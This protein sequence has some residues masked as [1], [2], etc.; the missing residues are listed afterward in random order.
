MF[1][2]FEASNN[3]CAYG[4]SR[5]RVVEFL[6]WWRTDIFSP[7]G[8]ARGADDDTNCDAFAGACRFYDKLDIVFTL[9]LLHFGCI[10]T[11]EAKVDWRFVM[12]SRLG[13]SR[14]K[15]NW[16]VFVRCFVVILC[17]CSLICILDFRYACE[18]A[19]CC[20]E[21]AVA[22]RPTKNVCFQH[23]CDGRSSLS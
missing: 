21:Y 1:F 7:S 14:V 8:F 6:A 10:C 15:W 18:N 12:Q 20:S 23:S 19:Y 5:M 11:V 9:Q 17:I 13:R 22:R 4:L 16:G 2:F 3:R